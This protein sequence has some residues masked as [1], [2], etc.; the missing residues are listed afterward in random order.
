MRADIVTAR[1]AVA[2]A[3]WHGRDRRHPRGH[4]RGGPARAAAPPPAQPVRRPG[5][6]EDLLDE[7]PRRRRAEPEP[8]R[9]VARTGPD[10]PATPGGG[11]PTVPDARH[12]ARRGRSGRRDAGRRPRRVLE[13][14][15]RRG[16]P[17]RARLLDAS[18]APAP[19]EAGR[20]LP[21]ASPSTGRRIGRRDAAPG[22]PVHLPRRSV[23]APHQPAR[24]RDGRVAPRRRPARRGARGPR[25]Q[26]GA[27]SASTRPARWPPASGWSRSRPPCCRCCS[28]PTSAATR[29]AWSRSAA[30]RAE[31]ALPPT[32]S[33]DIAARRL[34]DLPAGGRTPLA[35]GLLEAARVLERERS[36]TRAGGRCWSSSPT[37]A[38]RTAGDAVG[39]VAA[40]RRRTLGGRRRRRRRRR[41]REPA[42][43]GSA[44]PRQLAEHLGA[45]HVP[46]GEVSAE[47]RCTVRTSARGGG[48]MPQGQPL[49][50]ARR[51]AHHP[52][53]P[54][55]AAADGAHRRRQGEVDRRLR[56][57]AARLEP[58]L[59]HRGLPVRE[60]GQVAH[61]R[62][63]RARAPRRAAR[64]DRR[65]RAGRVAQDGL[66][67]V[68]VAQAG[69][70]RTTTPPPPPRAGPRS[71]AGSP[72]RRTTSTCST[73]SPTR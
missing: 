1:T 9:M 38:R 22:G 16:R 57:R 47:R 61:R 28:T 37:A 5:L 12:P 39:A 20:A 73:S 31:L 23:A 72:R 51:R 60:V 53:A 65:G 69:R 2:H 26:P 66:G 3:A 43:C 10:G 40:G 49:D 62:A 13:S 58:G 70:P 18:T 67:L 19:G 63:D 34:D 50:R 35:E 33:V 54:Q 27:A 42:G 52:A 36:A 29:S 4:P 48:L 44:W 59:V 25:G 17:Y 30:T 7:T 45:E 8:I 55:P 41:L 32:G 15:S 6:D 14:T 21:R 68:V 24:T 71:S 11:R 56:A 46:V 64:G